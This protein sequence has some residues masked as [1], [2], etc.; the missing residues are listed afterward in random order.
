MVM[1]IGELAREPKRR[2]FGKLHKL[3]DNVHNRQL[4]WR[5]LL[6]KSWGSWFLV[7]SLIIFGLAFA[8]GDL[9]AQSGEGSPPAKPATASRAA[10]VELDNGDVLHRIDADQ[11]GVITQDELN[12]FFLDFDE[13]G[14]KRLSAKE[15]QAISSE[16][17]SEKIQDPNAGRLAAFAR[18]DANKN[19]A[20]DPSEW[21]GKD[22]DFRYLDAN[23]DGTL[24]RE[25]F[26]SRNGR[27]WNMPFESL[28]FDGNGIIVRAEWLDSNAS[29][30]NLDWDHNGV[31]DRYEFYK[32]R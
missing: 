17:E 5:V 2:F 6:M 32:L 8:I 22:A 13:N 23:R 18:L 21:P 28:D 12:R 31:I 20:I 14:D 11:D 16:I 30:D 27:W 3:V 7:F 19:D 4:C 29:F 24:S 15:L 9:F 10:K 26:L 25:E 1:Q